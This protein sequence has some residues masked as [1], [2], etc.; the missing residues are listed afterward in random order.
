MTAYPPEEPPLQ[1]RVAVVTG[2]SRGIGRAVAVELAALGAAVV[3][4]GRSGSPRADIAGTL[5][6]T[7]AVIERAGGRALRVEADLLV[8]ADLDRL[9][10][11]THDVL[12]PVGILVNNAAYIGDAVFESL[13]DMSEDSWQ[14]MIELNVNVP[15]LLT[16]RFAPEMCQGGGGL[17]FN[18]VS[19]AS[20]PPGDAPM[21]LPGAGGLGAAYPTS[22]AAL[23]QLTAYVGNELRAVGVSMVGIDPGFARSES[24]EILAGRLGIDPAW[25]QPVEV[26]ARAIGFIAVSPEPLRYACTCVVARELVD[27]HSL[28]E[29]P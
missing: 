23:S 8:A 3:V 29:I 10:D 13:W 1:G 17:I 15:W 9:V 28:L 19:S 24:A 12:G 18:V 20:H 26:A 11:Q 25:A 21:P 14:A 2:A 6:E 16:K 22:K 4:T 5:D 7:V 27:A